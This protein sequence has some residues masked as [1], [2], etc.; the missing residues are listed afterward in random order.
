MWGVHNVSML[1]P[2]AVKALEYQEEGS[3]AQDL[4]ACQSLRA[5][6]LMPAWYHDPISVLDQ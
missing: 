3:S 5:A 6:S 2:Q 1:Q 4:P